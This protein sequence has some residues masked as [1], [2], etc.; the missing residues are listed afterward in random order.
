[1]CVVWILLLLSVDY[2]DSAVVSAESVVHG[3]GLVECLLAELVG[4]NAPSGGERE[5]P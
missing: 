1:M 5:H 2:V 4:R 3:C